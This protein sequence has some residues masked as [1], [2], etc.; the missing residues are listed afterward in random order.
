[1]CPLLRSVDDAEELL[2]VSP[3]SKPHKN[4]PP[5]PTRQVRS[6]GLL[7][8]G[9][10]L[11][12]QSV[13]TYECVGP[14]RSR[15]PLLQACRRAARESLLPFT[16][17][18]AHKCVKRYTDTWW[19]LDSIDVQKVSCTPTGAGAGGAAPSG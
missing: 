2:L 19:P 10:I 13:A 3:L 17:S 1:M 14:S 8:Q 9:G 18:A 12:A 7:G 16:S 4:A 6:L 15:V 11:N 5:T